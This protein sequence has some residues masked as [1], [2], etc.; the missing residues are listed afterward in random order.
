VP[1][2]VE[3]DVVEMESVFHWRGGRLVRADGYPPHADRF[4]QAGYV[5]MDLLADGHDEER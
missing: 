4:E 3:H 2:R 5:L 1:G